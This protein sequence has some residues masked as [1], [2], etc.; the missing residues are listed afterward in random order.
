MFSVGDVILLHSVR[1]GKLKYH[2]CL[3]LD[4]HYVFLNSLKSKYYPSD[5]VYNCEELPFLKTTD[6]GKGTVSCAY[7][8]E[9][10]AEELARGRAKKLGSA[11][12]EFMLRL[13]KFVSASRVLTADEKE[14]FLN[15]MGDWL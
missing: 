15:A 6:T 3:S 14:S 7:I 11:D 12:R 8:M 5:F 9:V 2:L 1:A 4:G 13:A 10:S